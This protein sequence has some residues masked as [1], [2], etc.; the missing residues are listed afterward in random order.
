M[1]CR[2][3]VSRWSEIYRTGRTADSFHD[4]HPTCRLH[5]SH[6]LM[7]TCVLWGTHSRRDTT[8]GAGRNGVAHIRKIF[9][10]NK[11]AKEIGQ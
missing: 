5:L 11:L 1:I 3:Y 7:A 8:L 2:S 10:D 6:F 9:W 4:S